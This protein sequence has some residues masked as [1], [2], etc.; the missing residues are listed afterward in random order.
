MPRC[1][2]SCYALLQPVLLGDGSG[3]RV[4]P[5]HAEMNDI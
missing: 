1:E 5:R 4:V 3:G 2:Y